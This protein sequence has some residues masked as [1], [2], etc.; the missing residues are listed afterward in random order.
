MP[1]LDSSLWFSCLSPQM[2]G[3]TGICHHT[4]PL[5]P[6]LFCSCSFFVSWYW[7]LK[8]RFFITEL[9]PLSFFWRQD[10]AKLTGWGL[11]FRSS[12]FIFSLCWNYRHVPPYLTLSLLFKFYFCGR[13]SEEILTNVNLLDG[14]RRETFLMKIAANTKDQC[15][16]ILHISFDN[17]GGT[18]YLSSYFCRRKKNKGSTNQSGIG[19]LKAIIIFNLII[20]CIHSSVFIEYLVC[21][22]Y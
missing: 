18:S 9:Q 8:P 3:T 2:A 15:Y 14:E 13:K 11:N 19:F 6:F 7:R 22:W 16:V 17:F 4:W 1:G 5:L 20:L 21:A 10:L 12:C